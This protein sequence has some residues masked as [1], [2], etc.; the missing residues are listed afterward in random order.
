MASL[1]G[2]CLQCFGSAFSLLALA[3]VAQGQSLRPIPLDCRL[4]DGPWQRCQMEVIELGRRWFLV[5]ENQRIEFRHDGT[6]HVR[7]GRDGRW[8]TVTPR[9]GEDQSLCWNTLCARGDIPLD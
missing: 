1:T 7:M 2:L 9:W 3:E 8:Q 5:V 6:G 4:G